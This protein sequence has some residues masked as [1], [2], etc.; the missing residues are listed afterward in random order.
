MYALLNSQYIL[1]FIGITSKAFLTFLKKN[2]QKSI[3]LPIYHTFTFYDLHFS[4]VKTPCFLH[5]FKAKLSIFLHFSK[6]KTSFFLH[7]S[8]I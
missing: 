3:Y 2:I 4:K 6:V 7:F 1:Q 5:F 8:K